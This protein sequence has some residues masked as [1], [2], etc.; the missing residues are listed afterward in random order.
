MEALLQYCLTV[1]PLISLTDEKGPTDAG[2]KFE[3]LWKWPGRRSFPKKWHSSEKK[4]HILV[5]LVFHTRETR[6]EN[7]ILAKNAALTAN[8]VYGQ[9]QWWCAAHFS[10]YTKHLH[11]IIQDPL[12]TYKTGESGFPEKCG[13]N[14]TVGIILLVELFILLW[15]HLWTVISP[16]SRTLFLLTFS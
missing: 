1:Q 5:Y 15:I 16:V 14:D 8:L 6:E 3:Q 4:Q 9:I 2:W 11:N 13:S 7:L 12:K 10:N